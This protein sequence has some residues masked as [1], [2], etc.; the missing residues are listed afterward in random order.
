MV[1]CVVNAAHLY[2]LPRITPNRPYQDIPHAFQAGSAAAGIPQTC[3]SFSQWTPADMQDNRKGFLKWARKLAKHGEQHNIRKNMILK[4][5][6]HDFEDLP[7]LRCPV[8]PIKPPKDTMERVGLHMHQDSPLLRKIFE[9]EFRLRITRKI[10]VGPGRWSQ[11]VRAKVQHPGSDTNANLPEVCV[12]LYDERF[13]FRDMFPVQADYD[14]WGDLELDVYNDEF[15][16]FPPA[17][18]TIRQEDAAYKRMQRFQG[19]FLPHYYGSFM[20]C[21]L[22]LSLA[23]LFELLLVRV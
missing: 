7:D 2:R 16:D 15:P 4:G 3:T 17:V 5:R 9:R 6:P 21:L 22:C 18:E 12:K 1:L 14:S 20:A 19:S 13:F 10:S 8:E 23:P 11:V